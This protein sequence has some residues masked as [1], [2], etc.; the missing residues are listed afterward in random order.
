MPLEVAG[1]SLPRSVIAAV[2]GLSSCDFVVFWGVF[3][4]RVSKYNGIIILAHE[5]GGAWW[6]GSGSRM[7][8]RRR[9]PR[10]E[11]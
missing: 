7:R 3:E 10:R 1:T 4:H 9:W 11:R 5:S 6:R 8:R 2:I